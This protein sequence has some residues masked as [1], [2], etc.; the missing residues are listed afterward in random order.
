MASDLAS[1]GIDDIDHLI[2]GGFPR[3][4]VVN[5]TGPP[6][7]G[8]TLLSLSFLSD[9]FRN[10]EQGV[11]VCF[12]TVPIVNVLKRI[13]DTRRFE[14]LFS[15]DE[16]IVMDLSDLT[17]VDILI[18]L[19]EDGGID[20]L[21]L[22]HPETMSLRDSAKWFRMMED[23]LASARSN[24]VTTLVVDYDGGTPA[25]IGRFVSDGILTLTR[26][27]EGRKIKVTKWDIDP[28]LVDMEV[29]EEVAGDWTN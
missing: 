19:I 16:P 17:R 21:V 7:S 3:G 18:G 23:L 29:S 11:Q 12:S 28:D 1:F 2:D 5:L 4:S 6:G 10:D 20:R 27:G 9:G 15:T 14:P 22:D 24:K 25:G 13:K 26:S 8:K